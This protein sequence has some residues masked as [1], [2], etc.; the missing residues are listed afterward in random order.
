MIF[1]LLFFFPAFDKDGYPLQKLGFPE[2]P[3]LYFVGLPFMHTL[4]S[5]LLAGVGNDAANVA[6][7]I[8]SYTPPNLRFQSPLPKSAYRTVTN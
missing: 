7:H 2:H 6:E 3:R 4:K 1:A 8:D 5:G